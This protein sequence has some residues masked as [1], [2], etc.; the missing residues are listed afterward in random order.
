MTLK[1]EKIN[2]RS[3]LLKAII[4]LG[5]KHRKFLGFFPKKAFVRSAAEGL[6][7]CAVDDK[8]AFCG[9]LLYYV[10]RGRAVIQQLCVEV[11]SRGKGVGHALVDHLKQI[12]NHLDG[13]LLHC[14]R[15]FP[16]HEFWPEVGFVAVGEKQG[17]GKKAT[18]LTRYWYDHC[19][20]DLFSYSVGCVEEAKAV[21]VLDANVLFD[22]QDLAGTDQEAAALD[23]PWLRENIEIKIT[24]E[25]LNEINRQNQA[26]ERKRRRGFARHFEEVRHSS[27]EVNELLQALPETLP[28]S[29]KVSDRSDLRQLAMALSGGAEFFITRDTSLC[30]CADGI[31]KRFGI[32]VTH[33]AEFILRFDEFL[34]RSAYQAVRLSGSDVN[35]RRVGADD[36]NKLS[37]SF[38][39][40]GEGEKRAQFEERLR[41]ALARPQLGEGSII[42]QPQEGLLGLVAICIENSEIFTVPFFRIKKGRLAGT[43]ARNIAMLVTKEII[44][45]NNRFSMVVI[46]DPYLDSYVSEGLRDVGFLKSGSAWIKINAVG[47]HTVKQLESKIRAFSSRYAG[48][49]HVLSG[50]ANMVASCKSRGMSH[51]FIL[52]VEQRVWPGKLAGLSIRNFVVPIRPRW[53]VHL[54]DDVLANQDLFGAERRIALSWENVYYRAKKPRVLEAPARILWYVSHDGRYECTMSVRACSIL[55][56]LAV[57][58]A[59]QLYKRYER[60]GVYDWSDVKET[61]KDDA[62]KEIMS[63]RFG[64]TE[65]LRHPVTWEETQNV[66]LSHLGTRPPLSTPLK[67]TEE[68]F[69]EIYM[70]GTSS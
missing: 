30:K 48:H 34:R 19:Q 9:Y 32:L 21:A 1:I 20:R 13:I 22:L 8:G 49:K 64:N 14:S 28:R 7:V 55:Q 70:L 69:N 68:C 45:R 62:E 33:P 42:E 12:T 26:D 41:S 29:K 18:S 63:F 16:A 60:L 5:D 58:K 15:D 17:R 35:V 25:I 23:A 65:L 47:I 51:D 2:E 3:R 37:R 6:I 27:S 31:Y 61:A 52:R 59:K 66:L 39:A 40:Y 57:G 46:I 44:N 10:A 38:L 36:V 11:R 50:L 53:A 43:L 67:I 56:E 54:F 24:S 4:E